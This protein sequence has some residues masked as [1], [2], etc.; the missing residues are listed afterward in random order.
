MSHESVAIREPAS[1][2][3][4][5]LSRKI[6]NFKTAFQ[7]EAEKIIEFYNDVTGPQ[8]RSER[9][10]TS[11]EMEW[12]GRLEKSLERLLFHRIQAQTDA[13]Y[14]IERSHEEGAAELPDGMLT[15]RVTNTV[16]RELGLR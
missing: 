3:Q 9:K 12:A 8:S 5:S 2:G 15:A 14:S 10:L 1:E 7:L 13:G 16:K 4:H 6:P 11:E